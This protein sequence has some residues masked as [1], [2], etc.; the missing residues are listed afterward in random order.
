MVTA[1]DRLKIDY[2]KQPVDELHIVIERVFRRSR[3]QIK[4]CRTADPDRFFVVFL[5]PSRQMPRY[6]KLLQY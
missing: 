2:N 5:Y 6:T 1:R 3:V 4:A